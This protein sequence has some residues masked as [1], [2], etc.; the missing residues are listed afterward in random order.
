[1][2]FLAFRR[3]HLRSTSG[4]IWGSGSF[5]VQFGD[6]FRSG[7]HL[8]SGI[9]CGALHFQGLFVHSL[10]PLLPLF[11][12]EIRFVDTVT[13]LQHWKGEKGVKTS[14]VI[15][16]RQLN[17]TG[18]FWGMSELL[19]SMIVGRKDTNFHSL[20]ERQLDCVC[21]KK[22]NVLVMGDF[23]SNVLRNTRHDAVSKWLWSRRKAH[24]RADHN[25]I[26]RKFAVRHVVKEPTRITETTKTFIDLSITSNR[27][28]ARGPK[29][30]S[31]AGSG[32]WQLYCRSQIDIHR[33][34]II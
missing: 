23:N 24:E 10:T 22:K 31:R 18:L 30:L 19:L 17:E 4:I 32:I 2:P 7:D 33:V 20:L 16:T 34:Q 26:M 8:W 6:H 25:V 5:A 11:N 13:W 3:D 14:R 21:K 12:A 9:I 29:L 28:K 15:T 1:M 27:T